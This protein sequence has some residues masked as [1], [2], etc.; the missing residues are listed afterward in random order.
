[1]PLSEWVR[2]AVFFVALTSFAI[3]HAAGCVHSVLVMV[4]VDAIRN[5]RERVVSLCLC[6]C[7]K[8]SDITQELRKA[9]PAFDKVGFQ[10]KYDD[11]ERYHREERATQ[12]L[13]REVRKSLKMI[14][15]YE[16]TKLEQMD[17]HKVK[18]SQLAPNPIVL[19][20]GICSLNEKQAEALRS[21]SKKT[22]DP[23]SQKKK[24]KTGSK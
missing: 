21:R 14:G 22:G 5:G 7:G 16:G 23:K 24:S 12:L 19:T 15:Q 3:S 10:S 17:Q 6:L 13:L 8:G 2:L 11:L 1:M 4:A 9:A 18:L 20:P